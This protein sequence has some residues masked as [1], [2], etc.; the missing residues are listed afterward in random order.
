MASR[1]SNSFGSYNIKGLS[2]ANATARDALNKQAASY[3]AGPGS[4]TAADKRISDA[5][6][7]AAIRAS[8]GSAVALAGG[9]VP[10]NIPFAQPKAKAVAKPKAKAPAKAVARRVGVPVARGPVAPP[11]DPL[12]TLRGEYDKYLTDIYAGLDT[13]LKG[14]Q[15][16][17][18]TRSAE[19]ATRLGQVYDDSKNVAGATATRTNEDLA[20]FAARMGIG[21]AMQGRDTA[22]WQ[23]TNE[24]LKSLNEVNRANSLATNDTIRTNYYDFL[25][26]KISSAKGQ[27]AMSRS[28]L[29]D[30]IAQA[31][32]ARQQ[33]QMAAAAAAARARSS[34]GRGGGSGGSGGVKGSTSE[35]TAMKNTELYKLFMNDP[36]VQN[37]MLMDDPRSAAILNAGRPV[38]QPKKGSILTNPIYKMV[39]GL[40]SAAAPPSAASKSSALAYYLAT[41]QAGSPVTSNVTKYSSKYI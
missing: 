18:K 21:E 39:A 34:R 5:D 13:T 16:Q 37:A 10:G 41:G 4:A 27:E 14:D 1:Y 22:D 17:Y 9:P 6:A 25:G 24:R 8:V 26:D 19:L 33:A 29:N 28:S 3:R 11:V 20:S 15:E 32:L 40:K 36:L 31:K 7:A 2:A 35:Q 12:D 23:Q 30:I 38:I